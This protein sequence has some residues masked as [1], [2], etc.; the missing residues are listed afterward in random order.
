MKR[1]YEALILSLLISLPASSQQQAAVVRLTLREAIQLALKSN[2]GVQVAGTQVEEAAGTRERRQAVLLPHVSASSIA[3]LQNRNL[4]AFGISLPGVPTVVGP[5]S[6]YDFRLSADQTLFDRQAYHSL[7]ASEGQ[8]EAAKLNY[9]DTRDVV[10]RQAAGLYLVAE[11]AAAEVQAAESRVTTSETLMNLAQDQ[12]AAGL[13]TAVDVLRSQVQLQ[14]DRQNL[15]VARN[16]YQSDLLILE[17]YV[18]MRPGTPIELADRL[19]FRHVVIPDPDDALRRSLENR[20]DYH[21]LLSQRESLVEQRKSARARYLPKLSVSGNYGALGRNFGEMPG[22]GLIQGTLSVALF[23]RDRSGEEKEL[24]SR[25]KRLDAQIA[26][27]RNGIEEEL[28]K[29]ALD[30]ESAEQQVNVTDAGLSLA[31]RELDLAKDRFRH[32]VTDNIEVITAQSSVQSAQ[33]DHIL[34]LARYADARVALLRA[35]G[36]TEKSY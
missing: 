24:E 20:S 19:E 29:S 21:S 27:L 16:T 13:A 14:R 36:V 30:L 4:R 6:N 8:Q 33:D 23:D 26:D 9:Q 25:L 3:N 10:V 35:L 31:Q 17:R 12:H 15:L 5:F 1:F 18:G 32:G 22:T 2:L 7:K 34:A 28:R 11:S